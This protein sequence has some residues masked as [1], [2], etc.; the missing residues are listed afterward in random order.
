MT[1]DW[2]GLNEVL[3]NRLQSDGALTPG[4]R[5]SFEAL[6]RHLF[7]PDRVWRPTDGKCLPVDK[8]QEPDAWWRLVYSDTSVVTQLDGGA[9]GGDEGRNEPT[10]SSS[11]PSMVAKMLP[12]LAELGRD[13][14]VLEVGTGT[15]WN[16]ALLAHRL[17]AENV[18]TVEVDKEIAEQAQANLRRARLAVE[19]V[20][21]EGSQG[22]SPN[23]PY[24]AVIV[25]CSLRGVPRALIA[26]CS[27]GAVLVAP[28]YGGGL[29]QLTVEADGSASGPFVGGADFMLMRTQRTHVVDVSPD[30]QGWRSPTALD[31]RCVANLGFSLYVHAHLPELRMSGKRRDGS[32]GTYMAWVEDGQGSAANADGSGYVWEYGPRA[33]WEAVER[34]WDGYRQAGSPKATEFGLRVTKDSQHIW[35][36]DPNTPLHF[37]SSG[38]APGDPGQESSAR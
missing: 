7:I 4:W 20:S 33:L 23:S 30:A 3:L 16:A 24:Q 31:S 5:P 21:G 11:M 17:G 15:G 38:S 12:D 9:E 37:R 28:I 35:L 14:K 19:V 25:T 1:C 36:R 29:V 8:T 10:S 22:H 34:L 32:N 18:T 13:T 6:P 26:Q 2:R 27:P